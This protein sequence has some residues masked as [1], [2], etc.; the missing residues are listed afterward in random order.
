MSNR[1]NKPSERSSQVDEKEPCR[2]S[3]TCTIGKCNVINVS[4]YL[5]TL[6]CPFPVSNKISKIKTKKMVGTIHESLS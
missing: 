1:I 5:V 3:G 2:L 4:S 6:G